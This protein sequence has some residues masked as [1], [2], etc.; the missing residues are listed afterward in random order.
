MRTYTIVKPDGKRILCSRLSTS[1][2][3]FGILEDVSVEDSACLQ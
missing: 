2:H 3:Q 1:G